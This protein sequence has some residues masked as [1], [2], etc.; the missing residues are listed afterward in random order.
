M[1]DPMA[2]VVKGVVAAV[3]ADAAIRAL[4]GDPVRIWDAAPRGAVFPHLVIGGGNWRETAAGFEVELSLSAVSRF[5]GQEEA[6]ELAGAVRGALEGLA[7]SQDGMA[8]R[9]AVRSVE[10]FAG[11]D[12]R[13]AYG[14]VR[15]RAVME[16]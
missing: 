7:L 2:A 9:V 16:G 11:A 15:L 3:S 1:S 12:R 5:D 6:R 14:V 4:S 8:G 13:H 10:V